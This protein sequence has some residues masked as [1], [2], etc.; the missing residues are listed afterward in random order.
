MLLVIG[1]KTQ[2]S[3]LS[4]ARAQHFLDPDQKGSAHPDT[5]VPDLQKDQ[6][7]HISSQQ[8]GMVGISLRLNRCEKF[9]GVAN[10]G[11]G[12]PGPPCPAISP[13]TKHS[14]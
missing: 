9:F 14:F 4:L 6:D 8:P 7:F 11:F 2:K 13:L 5:Q 10:E 12:H 3:V 1:M